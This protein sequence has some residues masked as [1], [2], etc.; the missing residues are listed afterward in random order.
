MLVIY[1]YG[2]QTVTRSDI[3]QLKAMFRG[4]CLEY[5]A[6]VKAMTFE[7]SKE[8]C[9]FWGEEAHECRTIALRVS[10]LIGLDITEVQ[11]YLGGEGS[12]PYE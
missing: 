9:D 4:L 5:Q 8:N 2:H 11:K 10:H 6:L 1:T 3:L 12:L 7:T